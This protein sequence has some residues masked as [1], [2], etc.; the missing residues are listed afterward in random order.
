MRKII[1]VDNSAFF[2]KF[3]K[4]FLAREGFEAES[5][6]S[7]QDANMAIA[8]GDFDMVIVGLTFVDAEGEKFLG[9]IRQSYDGPIV[10]ISSSVDNRE[11][12]IMSMG[13]KDAISKSGPWQDRLRRHLATLKPA[14]RRA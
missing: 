11:E 5:F 13:V 10:V 4:S 1:H 7:A 8:G 12:E 14:P 2:R 6:D 3:M 9:K